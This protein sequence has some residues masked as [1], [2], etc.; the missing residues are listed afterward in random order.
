MPNGSACAKRQIIRAENSQALRPADNTVQAVSHTAEWTKCR[1]YYFDCLLDIWFDF[2]L[3]YFSH[4][5]L[6]QKLNVLQYCLFPTFRCEAAEVA[7]IE[8]GEF[9]ICHS[10]VTLHTTYKQQW[11]QGWS[12][13][14]L[15][16]WP[17]LA[18][19]KCRYKQ[20]DLCGVQNTLLGFGH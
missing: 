20:R 14:H 19:T 4:T 2:I 3:T 18:C 1:L 12:V 11:H 10:V 13:N 8:M 16:N 15:I 7:I 5:R 17:R 9:D 6:G